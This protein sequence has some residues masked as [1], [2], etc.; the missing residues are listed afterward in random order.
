RAMRAP[1]LPSVLLSGLLTACVFSP[2]EPPSG[3]DAGA[4][5]DA[6]ELEEVE[7]A[8]GWSW[9]PVEGS[10]CA[11]GS[12]AGLALKPG[13]DGHELFL[14]VQGGGACWNEGTCAPSY[15]T[16]GPLCYYNP[17]ALCVVDQPG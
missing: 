8:N 16:N 14:Y 13:G 9:L 2:Q 10:R 5:S 11:L 15:R 3:P 7:V 1:L 4:S 6:G 17:N 12:R